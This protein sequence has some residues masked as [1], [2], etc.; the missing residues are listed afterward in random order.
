MNAPVLVIHP[1]QVDLHFHT[2]QEYENYFF[3]QITKHGRHE[4]MKICADNLDAA[5]EAGK[6]LGVKIAI[7]CAKPFR[8]K[9]FAEC[10]LM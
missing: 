6:K 2:V 1:G 7:I 3:E 4:F 8:L 10:P 9:S 5:A